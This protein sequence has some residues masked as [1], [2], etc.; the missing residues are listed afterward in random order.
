MS[1]LSIDASVVVKL[2]LA[3]ESHRVSARRLLRDCLVNDVTLIAPP[4]FEAEVDSVIR[5]RVYDGRLNPTDARKAFVGLDK[6]PV[7][8]RAHP[9]LRQRTREIAEQFNLRTVYDASYAA[10]AELNGCEFWTADKVFCSTVKAGLTFVKYL[11]D[12][13]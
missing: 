1:E 5:K 12:Y 3:G 8:L 10:L 13:Q 6:I 2:V 4:F 11:P 7:R 9:H